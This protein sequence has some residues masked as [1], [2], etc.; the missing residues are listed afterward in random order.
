MVHTGWKQEEHPSTPTRGQLLV[1]TGVPLRLLIP[2]ADMSFPLRVDGAT[3]SQSYSGCT[4]HRGS[5]DIVGAVVAI[6]TMVSLC[7]FPMRRG[8]QHILNLSTSQATVAWYLVEFTE[9]V[10]GKMLV[11]WPQWVPTHESALD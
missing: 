9:F 11:R 1:E 10:A 6:L 5:V 4:T 2:D 7:M 8:W 3:A